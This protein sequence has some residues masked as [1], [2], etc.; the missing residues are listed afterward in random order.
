MIINIDIFSERS[1]DKAIQELNRYRLSLYDKEEQLISHAIE[2]GEV[3]AS[4]AF[5]QADYDGTNDVE[6]TRHQMGNFGSVIATGETV[7][8]IEFGTGVTNPEWDGLGLSEY[9]PPEKGSFGYGQGS[10]EYG[11]SYYGEPGTNG[12]PISNSGGRVWTMGNK[13]ANAMWDALIIMS[14]DIPRIAME[15]FN[16]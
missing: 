13:P 3:V 15:V 5:E 11:W 10:N 14:E 7:G 12:V 16:K 6:V 2:L 9:E 4:I 8:F 1:I